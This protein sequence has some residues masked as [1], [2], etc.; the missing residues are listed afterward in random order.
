ME[1][2]ALR[3]Q[4]RGFRKEKDY[5]KALPLYQELWNSGNESDGWDGWGYAFCLEKIGKIS[6]AL[7]V[8]RKVYKLGPEEEVWSQL[9]AQCIYKLEI[10]K[11]PVEDFNRFLKAASGILKLVPQHNIY[12][13][14]TR[15]VFKVCRQLKERAKF[16]EVLHWLGR[17][18]V[19]LLSDKVYEFTNERGKRQ[20]VP[21]EL[22]QYYGARCRALFKTSR[23]E[24]CQECVT[25]G[26]SAVKKVVNEGDL[27]LERLCAKAGAARGN[28]KEAFEALEALLY[29]KQAWFLYDELAR[30]AKRLGKQEVAWRYMILCL[31]DRSP[32]D[33]RVNVFSKAATWLSEQGNEKKA[34]EHMQLALSIR[35]EKGWPIKGELLASAQALRIETEG[36]PPSHKLI[37]SLRGWW[38]Q[39]LEELE[40]RLKG[41][42]VRLISEG[43]AGFIESDNK[44]T[45]F[46]QQRYVKGGPASE[47]ESVTFKT[48]PGFDKKRDKPTVNAVQIKRI[49]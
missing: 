41:R 25:E 1:A 44:T 46:F 43:K 33:L 11:E 8:C 3:K 31:N 14:Y 35:H 26:L 2:S 37:K 49:G 47:G 4:A 17:L 45:Y 20:Q 30:L 48:A 29:R 39:Q 42:V 28:V 27:W 18:D 9:Y 38:N 15:T 7:E 5:K 12:A 13:P 24:A 6:D 16:E 36:L 23:F 10:D 34:A 19:S 40:P 22:Q 32:A 21:S